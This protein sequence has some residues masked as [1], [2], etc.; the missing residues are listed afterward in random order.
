MSAVPRPLDLSVIGI[1]VEEGAGTAGCAMG[2]RAL[3]TAGL[4]AALRGLGHAVEDLGDVSPLPVVTAAS[5]PVNARNLAVV[6]AFAKAARDATAEALARHRLPILLGGD[7][8]LSMGS[9]AAVAGYCAAQ[10]RPLFVLWLDAHADFNTPLTSPS[11]NLHGMAAA[12][13]VREPGLE[14]LIGA[15]EPAVDPRNLILFGIRS[16]DTAERGL[17][18]SRGIDVVDMR[19]ID[20]FGVAVLVR[21]V[22]DQVAAAG[23]HL[24][25]SLDLDVMDPVVAPGVGTPVPGGL[26]YRE[27]HLVLEL[28]YESGCLGS[29]DVVELNPF[30]DERGKSALLLVDLVAS[31]F[32]RQIS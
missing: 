20:E 22:I 4:V 26:T 31:L 7:H 9:V 25:V 24:H 11:G 5:E 10:G 21:R 28:L 19:L 14:G 16:I 17:L 15:Q 29:L 23:G 12:M 32:G 8:S 13:L 27:M 2:P 18:R 1:P 30:L 3:R 6:G